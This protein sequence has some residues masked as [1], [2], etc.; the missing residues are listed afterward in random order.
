[1]L[2]ALVAILAAAGALGATFSAGSTV[3]G[4]DS[5]SGYAVLAKYF[6]A[7]GTGGQSGTIVFRA[8]QGVDDPAVRAAMQ[9]LF[10]LVDAGFPDGNGVPHPPGP[11][12]ISPTSPPTPAP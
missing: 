10:A 5:A 1:G 12:V 3:P 7:L 6:P 4:S 2:V 11:T 9:E 8:R